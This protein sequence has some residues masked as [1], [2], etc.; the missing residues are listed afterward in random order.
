MT[1]TPDTKNDDDEKPA[2]RLENSCDSE[3]SGLPQGKAGPSVELA[4][5]KMAVLLERI[6]YQ[7]AMRQ[8]YALG[9]R[10]GYEQAQREAMHWREKAIRDGEQA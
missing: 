8:A 7:E 4:E 5:I 1:T 9:Q 10:D 3:R 6:D 2:T